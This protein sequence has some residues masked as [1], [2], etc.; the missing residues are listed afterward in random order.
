MSTTIVLLYVYNYWS[1]STTT[2]FI[3]MHDIVSKITPY[4]VQYIFKYKPYILN[5]FKNVLYFPP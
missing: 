2:K 1:M 5:V 4:N 3:I